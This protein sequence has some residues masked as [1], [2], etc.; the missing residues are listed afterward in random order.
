MTE[1]AA[2][3]MLLDDDDPQVAAAAMERLLT[4]D[5]SELESIIAPHRGSQDLLGGRLRQ[6]EAILS[7]K[8]RYRELLA[9]L[10]RNELKL[11]EDMLFINHLLDPEIS[12]QA[13]DEALELLGQQIE[14]VDVGAVDIARAMKELGYVAPQEH[15][16]DPGLNLIMD[17]IGAGTASPLMLCIIAQHL[18]RR[19]GWQATVVLSKGRHCLLDNKSFFVDPGHN[20]SVTQLKPNVRVYPC[21]NRDLLLTLVSQLFLSQMSEGHLRSIYHLS[22]M[23]A[24]LGGTKPESMPFPVGDEMRQMS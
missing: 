18:G 6:V 4:H 8:K 10:E 13:V 19:L 9:R 21:S 17:I 20:W 3:I 24:D 11:W 12:Q 22:R 7:D 16:L 1:I 15:T 5:E 23:M 2:L 14:G